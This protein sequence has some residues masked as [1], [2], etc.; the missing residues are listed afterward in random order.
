MDRRQFV[1]R[2][3]GIASTIAL[4][5]C[6]TDSLKA[7]YEDT[8]EKITSVLISQDAKKLVVIG[9]KYHYV[10]DNVSALSAVLNSSFRPKLNGDFESF[11][12]DRNN[13]ITGGYRLTI[14]SPLSD[15]Q[16]AE[17]IK[18]GFALRDNSYV[19]KGRVAGTRFSRNEIKIPG[20][21]SKLNREYAIQIRE[22]VGFRQPEP[23]PLTQLASGAVLIVAIPL[24]FIMYI[25]GACIPC[26]KRNG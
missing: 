1:T 10:F 16:T 4:T 6:A 19:F 13:H 5:G 7:V 2:T 21:D 24:F 3:L 22:H 12:V 8:N 15:E 18:L 25:F 17:A 20:N 11:E 9:A 14:S 26:M 23:S